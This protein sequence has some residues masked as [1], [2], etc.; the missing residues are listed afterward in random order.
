MLRGRRGGRD[1]CDMRIP[2]RVYAKR[3]SGEAGD[4][5]AF[6]TSMLI[7]SDPT[8]AKYV[9]QSGTILVEVDRAL[10]GCI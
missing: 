9:T 1:R 7:K 6:I 10:Y 4:Q 5:H 2:K 3:R 8:M